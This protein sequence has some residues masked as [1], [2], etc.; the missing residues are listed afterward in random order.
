MSFFVPVIPAFNKACK[1]L[2]LRVT[3][4]QSISPDSHLEEGVTTLQNPFMKNT[5]NKTLTALNI[6]LLILV[7]VGCA[8]TSSIQ[9]LPYGT[10]SSNN[11]LRDSSM[12]GNYLLKMDG[13]IIPY[14][15][16]ATWRKK[17]ITT[18]NEQNISNSEI[19]GFQQDG[20]FYGLFWGY[21]EVIAS[22]K[23]TIY[24]MT[25]DIGTKNGGTSG[26]RRY[27]YKTKKRKLSV[28]ELDDLRNW[29]KDCPHAYEKISISSS[30][31]REK[32]KENP[33]Y[34]NEIVEYYNNGCK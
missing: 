22:G 31:I 11:P 10:F 26:F 4:L 8:T 32:I 1:V 27:G 7:L 19:E 3:D 21:R 24:V 33:R 28:L 2:L 25:Q 15:G 16:K 18:V 13:T 9:V 17:M 20:K 23:I 29:V 5:F 34:L 6:A 14:T 30:Q 12:T